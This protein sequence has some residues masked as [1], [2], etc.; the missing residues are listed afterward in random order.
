MATLDATLPKS[1]AHRLFI[2][3]LIS[4]QNEAYYEGLKEAKPTKTV[5]ESPVVSEFGDKSAKIFKGHFLIDENI[6]K[7]ELRTEKK[8]L[9]ALKEQSK[10]L[11]DLARFLS[12]T[13]QR[14]NTMTL[15][16]KL[17]DIF[18]NNRGGTGGGLL[19]GLDVNIGGGFGGNVPDA[20]R[21]PTGTRTKSGGGR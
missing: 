8:I 15:F 18:G 21:K 12:P 10:S 6:S 7:E 13:A 17:K 5:G 11:R 16:D 20:K 19:D 14:K 4:A 9:A 1:V 2:A 3:S